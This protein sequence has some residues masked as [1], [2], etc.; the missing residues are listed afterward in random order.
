MTR[1]GYP[2]GAVLGVLLL[3]S[4]AL[5]SD[6]QTPRPPA[7]RPAPAQPSKGQ[8]PSDG[9][10]SVDG[11]YQSHSFTFDEVHHDN[12]F[13]EESTWQADYKL[14]DGFFFGAGGGARVWRNVVIAGA[15]SQSRDKNPASVTASIAHPFF[16]DRFRSISGE[17]ED[18]RQD[19]HALHISAMWMIPVNRRLEI[20]VF[21]GPSYFWVTREFVEDVQY[22]ETFP[23]D[24]ATFTGVAVGEAQANHLGGHVGLDLTWLFTR[25]IG[26][27]ALVRYSRASVD[28]ET[29]AGGAASVDVG[30]FQV[31]A[32]LRVRFGHK[33]APAGPPRTAPTGPR[34]PVN[35]P[36]AAPGT[37]PATVGTAAFTIAATPVYIRAEETRTPLKTLPRGTSIRVLE[38]AGDWLRIEF[39]DSQWG[40]RVGFVQRKNVQI[41]K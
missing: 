36:P 17:S 13:V 22:A 8:W 25:E 31:G 7:R 5:A 3:C 30:G 24:T 10:F 23:Y 26:V 41:T 27:G 39:Q 40:R 34:P 37:M 6:D 14:S 21:G 33:G 32:G 38:E 4:P 11:G 19:E 18:L 16:F 12:R 2:V 20:G 28:F 1:A 15:Y 29:P 9:F 35:A